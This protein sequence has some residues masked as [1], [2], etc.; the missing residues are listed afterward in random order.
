MDATRQ[1]DPSLEDPERPAL[2]SEMPSACLLALQIHLIVS[3]PR[4]DED[5]SRPIRRALPDLFQGIV[6]DSCYGIIGSEERGKNSHP[7]THTPPPP[8]PADPG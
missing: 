3:I 6:S 4:L 5:E 8:A 1:V 7:T 2:L